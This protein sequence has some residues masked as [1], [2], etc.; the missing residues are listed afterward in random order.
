MKKLMIAAAIVCAAAFATAAAVD[1]TASAVCEP[2]NSGAKVT[3]ASGWLG[4]MILAEDLGDVTDALDSGS[5]Q[6]LVDSALGPVKTSSSKG[7]FSA[8]TTS[9]SV[10]AGSQTFYMIVLNNGTASK[11][12]YYYVSNATTTTVDASLP[13][14]VEFGTQKYSSKSTSNWYAIPEPT[15]GLLLLLGMAGLALKRKRA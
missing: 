13:T 14:S 6:E 7:T 3:P 4:Y 9:S 10:A 11:A 15:S 5:T 12:T 8:G 2:S 1:W